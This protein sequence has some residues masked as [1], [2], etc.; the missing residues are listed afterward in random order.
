MVMFHLIYRSSGT[1]RLALLLLIAFQFS[2]CGSSADR[3][4]SYYEH[5]TKLL[6]EHNYGWAAIEFKNAIKLKKDLVPAWRGLAQVEELNHN[7]QGLVPILR[8]IV[9]LDP[10]DVGTTLKLAR[11][12]L[13]SGAADEAL[14][15]V[16]GLDEGDNG[17]AN[18]L[19]LK[20]AIFYKL[21]DSSGAVREAQAA[22]KIDPGNV[23]AM[24]VLAADRL[25]NGDAKGALHI[26]DSDP[27]QHEKD[28][29][30]QLFKIK[31]FEQLGDLPEVE[32]LLRK[33]SELYPQ[34]IAFRKQLIKFYIDQHRQDDAE[35]EVR[36]IAAADPKNS[37]AGLDLIRF[38]YAVRGPVPARQ[39]LVARINAGGEVFPYQM[40]LAEFDFAQGNVTDSFKL[41]ETLA[42][43]ASS[44]EHALT[45]KIKLAEMK[46]DRKNI[47]T[48]EALVSD[49]L[50]GDS[51]NI[52]ALK[53]RA[54]IRMDRGQLEPA[55]SD[56]REAL[57]DQSRSTELMLLLA[58]AY[59]RSGSIALAE[60]Q[61][62]DA[63]RASDFDA[64]VGL[65]YVAFLRRRGSIE[66]AEDVLTELSSR[67]PKNVGILSALAE[68]KLTRQDWAGAQ[69]IGESIRHMGD[70]SG[71]ADQILGAAL[72]G[73]HKNDE[74]IAAFQNAVAAAPSAVQPMVS[75]VRALV[76]ANQ[77]DR[78][79][80]FLESVLKTNPAN[81]E[82]HV[83]LGSIRLANN[84]PD[85]AMKSFMTAIEKQPKDM[86]GYRALADLYLRQKNNDA[87]L[88]VIRSGLKEQPDS[89]IL[90]L[91][92]AGI[93][94]QNGDYSAAISE[95]EYMLI[96]QPGSMIAA[97]NLASM[98]SDHRTDKASLE[99]AESLAASLRKSQVPQ[100]KDT[101]GWVS[102]RRGDFKAA[103]PLL[104]EAAAALP[105]LA[106]VHYHLGMGYV[107]M[108]QDGKASEEFTAALAKAPNAELEKTIR[109][110]L[111]KITTQ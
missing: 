7:W 98:L 109:A 13:L 26:L 78:A 95:Y 107:A 59:E 76:H 37:G 22:L 101:L 97:N 2:G 106:S 17:N 57:N 72:S 34:E 25:A 10:K 65:S 85:Q 6:A 80:S 35:K 45:A 52:S 70:S 62:A 36:A 75:L 4:Q 29:G 47:D 33:L 32:S 50:R 90:H 100:F 64:G 11:L 104:E 9:E 96:Q 43:N 40:A 12:M 84:A 51:R 79:V 66:R 24:M 27:V 48:A 93:L 5:G 63:T 16:N 73:R 58:T 103:V 53:L 82:A 3:A 14:K 89:I 49:I 21:K 86:I 46:F 105:N 31:I 69:E 102:Y 44:P 94:E 8:T 111:K 83:L 18:V 30:V 99:R 68:V 67:Q 92:L 87:A 54:S 110:E 20:A 42:S 19:A 71:I 41:L 88:K 28:L 108:G 38:L 91:A 23:D 61:F 74:S 77:T 55:I 1:I 39:E 81:A 15:L 56:L 60:K